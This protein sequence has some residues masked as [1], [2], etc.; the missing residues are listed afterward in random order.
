[1]GILKFIFIVFLGAFSLG[2]I[3][4]FD[5][6]SNIYIK[7]VDVVAVI[8]LF[9]WIIYNFKSFI[10]KIR[11]DKLFSPVMWVTVIMCI[12][13]AVNFKNFSGNEIMIGLSYIIR[14]IL[15]ASLFF[16]IKSF[17]SKFKE[18]ILYMLLIMG[19]FFT[20]FGFIQ[21]FFYSNLRNL[22]YLGW[23]EHMYRMFST[24]LDPNFAGAFFVAYLIFLLGLLS[25]FLKNN[26]IKQA[27]LVGLISIFS[28]ISVFLSYSR[29]ALI[30]LLTSIFIFS[31]LTK[32]WHWIFGFTLISLVFILISSRSFN[33][34][35]INLFRI[36]S[37]EARIDSAKIAINIIKDNPFL[38]VGF[39][40]Y[41]YA[42]VKYGFRNPVG[43]S[44]S[45]ADAGTDNSF[46][47][48]L[49]TTGIIGL[50]FYL[51]LLWKIL[52]RPYL[53]YSSYGEK[54]IRKYIAII[55]ASSML[56]IIVNSFFINS[57]F[58]PFILA[59][60]WILLG[61]ISSAGS[62]PRGRK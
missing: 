57:L 6:G 45:H 28:L 59:W 37:A 60:M 26:K 23:D 14:W 49:A 41:R 2:E 39:N 12:S 25:Y 21:Y 16:I 62:E 33:V 61:L 29:S 30:M 38:G 40:T 44:I 8:L 46:L 54:D 24:F 5:L 4:R 13:L 20:L 10:K 22:Y 51:N 35:N 50:I 1:M 27:S 15:Y 53:N 9:S 42:Q 7:P 19:G 36:T 18:K 47:F 32:K 3:I 55:I 43:S 17:S 58:Y 52:K 56:G 34:E 31:V 48:V 11:S